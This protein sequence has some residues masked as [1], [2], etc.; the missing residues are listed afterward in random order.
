LRLREELKKI[1]M[2]STS[3][4]RLAV[5]VSVGARH[6]L[7]TRINC[8]TRV[9]FFC[10]RQLTPQEWLMLKETSLWKVRTPIPLF[11]LLTSILL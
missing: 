2:K 11:F 8:A 10:Q 5:L 7:R 6:H 9:G 4:C 3:P 1:W